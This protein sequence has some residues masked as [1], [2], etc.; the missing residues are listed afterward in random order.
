MSEFADKTALVTGG[1]RGIGR[2]I[3]AAL[4]ECGATVGLTATTQERADQAAASFDSD[5]VKGYAGS[6]KEVAECFLGDFKRCDILVC[7]AGVTR[8]QLALALGE[9]DWDIVLDTI[10]SRLSKKS[11]AS[12]ADSNTASPS[13]STPSVGIGRPPSPIITG[14]GSR[15]LPH[16]FKPCATSVVVVNPEG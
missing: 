8:D 4:H 3:V 11:M 6:A 2:A 12:R 16:T 1:S 9:E 13:S 15:R 7:N 14:S 5:R 10:P